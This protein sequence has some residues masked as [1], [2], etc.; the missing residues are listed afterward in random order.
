MGRIEA[1]NAAT[2]LVNSQLLGNMFKKKYLLGIVMNLNPV[3]FLTL[4]GSDSS[5]Q[6]QY[7]F[8]FL[9]GE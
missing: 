4:S 9:Y 5:V 8:L 3:R 1:Y 6:I 7:S 2:A